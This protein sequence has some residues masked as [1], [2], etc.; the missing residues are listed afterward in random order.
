MAKR[1][2][3][4]D[5]APQTGQY[6]GLVSGVADLLERSRRT[7]ARTVNSILTATYWEIGRQI[8]EFEPGGETRAEYA[9]ELLKRLAKDRTAR[10]GRGFSERNVRQMR[11]FH[12]GWEIGQTPSAKFEARGRKPK[13]E[14]LVSAEDEIR[15]SMGHMPAKVFASGYLTDLPHAET[16]RR[17]ILETKHALQQRATRR[18]L[19]NG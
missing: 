3:K 14:D 9:S 12:Q 7:T 16:L 19:P 4:S 5:I 15:Y 18:G 8:V 10:F 1:R 2:N 17:E 6:N 13:P 11:A